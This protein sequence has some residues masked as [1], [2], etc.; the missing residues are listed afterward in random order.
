MLALLM[1]GPAW[2]AGSQEPPSLRESVEVR[3]PCIRFSDLLG[4]QAPPDLQIRAAKIELGRSPRAGSL[5][6]LTAAQVRAQAQN[7]IESYGLRLPDR[8]TVRRQGFAIDRESLWEA[9]IAYLQRQGWVESDLPQAENLQ[10]SG[11]MTVSAEQVQ[12]TLT[13]AVW[14]RATKLLEMNARC[15]SRAAC[16]NFLVRVS[17]PQPPAAMDRV[18]GSLAPNSSEPSFSLYRDRVRNNPLLVA[19]GQPAI[20]QLEGASIHISLPVICLQSGGLG[21]Q[22]RAR[23]ARGG[24]S[25]SAKVTGAGELLAQF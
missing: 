24:R 11:E 1:M 18:S 17:L 9:V 22:V 14:N 25:F 16:E 20:L 19:R 23:E 15:T 3:D 2:R 10:W 6:V 13:G 8:I 7:L 12:F 5:R 21:E 4:S